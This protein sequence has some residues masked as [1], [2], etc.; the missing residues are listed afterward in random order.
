MRDA[1]RML[2]A[3]RLCMYVVNACDACLRVCVGAMYDVHVYLHA[4]M[5]LCE[6]TCMYVGR[7]VN[8]LACAHVYAM[9]SWMQTNM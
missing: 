9:Q 1:W 5:H 3:I 8:L 7:C 2:C 6:Y 4:C